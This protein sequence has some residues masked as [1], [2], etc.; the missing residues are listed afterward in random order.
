[1]QSSHR[2]LLLLWGNVFLF[3][4]F[5]KTSLPYLSWNS[6]KQF[7]GCATGIEFS[8]G[9]TQWTPQLWFFPS[10]VVSGLL[11]LQHEQTHTCWLQLLRGASHPF[12]SNS[13]MSAFHIPWAHQR[14]GSIWEL[15][16]SV[17]A[18]STLNVLW[19][20]EDLLVRNSGSTES[21]LFLKER[22]DYWTPSFHGRELQNFMN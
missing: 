17:V 14:C 19:G 8:W 1:M 4:Q 3:C 5:Y 20:D 6:E 21:N 18:V 12:S 22:N 11:A 2:R 13:R 7:T 10:Q 9:K 16:V 15:E